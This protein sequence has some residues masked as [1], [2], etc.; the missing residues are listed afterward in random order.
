[1]FK[2]SAAVLAAVSGSLLT[3]PLLAAATPSYSCGD[4]RVPQLRSSGY[5]S[6]HLVVTHKVLSCESAR[7]LV[8]AYYTS[9]REGRGSGAFRTLGAYTCGGGLSSLRGGVALLCEHPANSA[10]V[11]LELRVRSLPPPS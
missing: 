5:S 1:M 4:V 6:E 8:T 2:R 11:V 7:K 9:H 3:F 10:N